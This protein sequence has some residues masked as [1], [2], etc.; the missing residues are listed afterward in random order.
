MLYEPSTARAVLVGHWWVIGLRGV[1]GIVFGLL[2]FSMPLP[3]IIHCLGL[4]LWRLHAAGW[5]IQ[6]ALC[7]AGDR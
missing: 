7:V 6:S 4:A 5:G 3:T 2:A 1:L